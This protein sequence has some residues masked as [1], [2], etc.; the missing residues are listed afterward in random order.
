MTWM[1]LAW[2]C[3]WTCMN[4]QQTHT[5]LKKNWP[6][7]F[8]YQ[9]L[10]RS[11]YMLYWIVLCVHVGPKTRVQSST[12]VSGR[13]AGQPEAAG[14]GEGPGNAWRIRRRQLGKWIQYVNSPHCSQA[15]YAIYIWWSNVR[16]WRDVEVLEGELTYQGG[17]FK[18]GFTPT[19]TC[20][21]PIGW[22]KSKNSCE[23]V[24]KKNSK[25]WQYWNWAFADWH[26]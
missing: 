23:R 1:T 20:H 4:N 5:S 13:L 3:L 9:L 12:E 22:R 18:P 7:Y 2:N 16:V 6:R 19:R 21:T 15:E 11:W 24:I 26:L 8:L 14:C 25:R 10:H 17:V